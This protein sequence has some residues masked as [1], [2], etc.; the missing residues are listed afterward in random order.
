VLILLARGAT[1]RECAAR[2]GLKPKTV[3]NHE[4]R[5]MRDL[6]LH[7]QI[8]LVRFAE[9]HGLIDGALPGSDPAEELEYVL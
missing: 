7:R 1:H 9:Y 4:T 8:E 2:L 5:L 3:D 6:G